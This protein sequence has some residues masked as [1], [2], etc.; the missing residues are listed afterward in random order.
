MRLQWL[1]PDKK[2]GTQRMFKLLI[3]QPPAGPKM[4]VSMQSSSLQ[5]WHTVRLSGDKMRNLS[6]TRLSKHESMFTNDRTVS[7]IHPLVVIGLTAFAFPFI[8]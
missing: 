4:D 7:G 3:Q 6:Q 2:I 8:D 5:G 1:Q